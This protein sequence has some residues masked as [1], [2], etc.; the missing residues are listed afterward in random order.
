M[1]N[2]SDL[3]VV[4]W[5]WCKKIF[6]SHLL[7]AAALLGALYVGHWDL[8]QSI[9][10]IKILALTEMALMGGFTLKRLWDDKITPHDGFFWLSTVATLVCFAVFAILAVSFVLELTHTANVVHVL[11]AYLFGEGSEKITENVLSTTPIYFFL[12]FNVVSYF[13]LG[14]TPPEERRKNQVMYIISCVDI[15]CVF[16]ITVLFIVAYEPASTG[17]DSTIL[18]AFVSG[19][20]ALL[21]I[22]SNTVNRALEVLEERYIIVRRSRDLIEA[23]VE[24]GGVQREA[25]AEGS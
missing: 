1:G 4:G 23:M 2:V 21:L 9:R 15:P 11:I 17:V 7:Y 16:A 19:A 12:F 24:A 20:L 8:L 3:T 6:L 10:L 13:F 14:A 22:V 25:E 5:L 18:D